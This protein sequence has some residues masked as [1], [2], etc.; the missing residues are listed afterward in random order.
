MT[1]TETK[2]QPLTYDDDMTVEEVATELRKH[3][4]TVRRWMTSA[5]PLPHRRVGS[6]IVLRRS[7]VHAWLSGGGE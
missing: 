3:H 7:E 4:A 1:T 6:Q 5:R 2:P